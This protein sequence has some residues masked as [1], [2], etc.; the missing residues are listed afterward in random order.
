MSGARYLL[1]TNAIV[2]LL[3][4]SSGVAGLLRSASWVGIS[5]VSH[6]EFLAYSGLG[7]EDE[8]LFACFCKR[9]ETVGLAADDDELLAETIRLRREARLKLPDAIIAATALSRE[10]TL[11]TAD[12]DF[13]QVSSLDVVS[14]I[15]E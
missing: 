1:D 15:S 3:N 2:L 4:G 10:A 7:A 12:D 5:V 14:P 13:K 6:L 9:V 8:A 11:I